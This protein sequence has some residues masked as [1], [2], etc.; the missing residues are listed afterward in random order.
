MPKPTQP[1]PLTSQGQ[2]A[3]VVLVVEDDPAMLRLLKD[4]LAFSGYEVIT[5]SDGQAGL[6]MATEHMPDLVLLDITLPKMDGLSVCRELRQRAVD[7]P[8]IML[9]A[10]N[11]EGDKLAGLK[12]GADDYLTKP[13]SIAELL[14]RVE[15]ML[16]RFDKVR[17][18]TYSFGNV[19]VNFRAFQARKR[20]AQI[21]L[22]RREFEILRYLVE[23]QGRVVQRKELLK[24]IWGY[25]ATVY[26]RTIDTHIAIL[27]RKLEDVPS[28]PRYIHTVHRVGYKFQDVFGE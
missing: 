1:P 12:I 11:L 15:A 23:N 3:R 9:T 16:R 13:F 4:N 22:A 20:G 27:R 28:N 25:R 6:A 24:N 2:C 10:R 18:D 19:W 14:A 17:L 8:I 5:A 21:E 7:C 26:T